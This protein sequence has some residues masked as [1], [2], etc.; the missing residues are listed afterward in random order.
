MVIEAAEITEKT[1]LEIRQWSGNKVYPS[2][3][4]EPTEQNPSGVYWQ[5]DTLEGV[6][7]AIPGDYII[8]GVNGEFYPCKADIFAKTYEVVKHKCCVGCKKDFDTCE[9]NTFTTDGNNEFVWCAEFE[10]VK[11]TEFR[12]NT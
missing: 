10:G 5:I 11:N 8:K 7:T 1:D 4:L 3:V 9:S 2:P 12:G 6:M